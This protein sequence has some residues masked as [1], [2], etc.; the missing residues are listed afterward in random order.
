[1]HLVTLELQTAEETSKV[2]HCAFC[3]SGSTLTLRSIATSEYALA[4]LSQQP[5]VPG[6]SLIV[7]RR[8]VPDFASLT[9]E[10]LADMLSLRATICAGLRSTLA[11]SG[12][13][14]AWNEGE[15]A[16]QTVPHFH[17]HVVPRRPEDISVLGYDPRS[18]FYRPGPRPNSDSDRLVG[19]A[20][21]LRKCISAKTHRADCK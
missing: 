7:P 20:A 5:I 3:R 13:N 17:L 8:C 10:E 18:H 14:Y 12:F 16:G 19:L 2:E 21:A 6:H 15:V 9:P 1:M 4:F 11:A